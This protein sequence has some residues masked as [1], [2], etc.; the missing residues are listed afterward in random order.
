MSYLE[1]NRVVTTRK[2]EKALYLGNLDGVRRLA[3]FVCC[4]SVYPDRIFR[5]C[6]E[7]R[8]EFYVNQLRI[9]LNDARAK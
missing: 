3:K 9:K 1:E 7:Q 8:N 5:A 6:E 2:I 4:A